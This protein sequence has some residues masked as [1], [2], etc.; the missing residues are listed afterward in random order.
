MSWV[1]VIKLLIINFDAMVKHKK[2]W[3]QTQNQ[4]RYTAQETDN[5]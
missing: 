5:R 3:D 2:Q 1:I 4:E